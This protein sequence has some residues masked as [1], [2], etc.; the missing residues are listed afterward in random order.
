[1]TFQSNDI[2]FLLGAGASSDAEIPTS[3][4][5]IER[6]EKELTPKPDE[7][8]NFLPLYYYFKS[9]IYYA[10]GLGGAFE[11]KANYNIERL[12]NTLSEVEKR[13]QHELYPFIGSWNAKLAELAGTDFRR[14]KT[15]RTHIL[16]LLIKWVSIRD[17][18]KA[19]YYGAFESFAKNLEFPIHIFSLNYDPCLERT[20]K[21][22]RGFDN[23]GKWNFLGFER[24]DVNI[25]LYK[26]HGSI[27]WERNSDGELLSVYDPSTVENQE[28]IFGTSYKFQY[29]DPYLWLINQFRVQCIDARLIVVVGYSFSDEHVNTILS[30]GLRK[31]G[32]KLL[33][34]GPSHDVSSE[35]RR[36]AHHLKLDPVSQVTCLPMTGKEFM[37]KH[38]NQETLQGVMPKESESFP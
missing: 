32:S 10:A 38:L 35:E 11:K 21:V 3:S 20:C 16:K 8:E 17:I 2:L 7:S 27:D 12:V 30:E 29:R 33:S 37:D 13:D 9:A 24:D 31:S 4:S 15:L 25:F 14:V 5:M 19:S 1:M 18:G 23:L 34:V 6:L 28:L 26:L 22:E 36:I